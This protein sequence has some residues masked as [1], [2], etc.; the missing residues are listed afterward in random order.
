ME[1]QYSLEAGRYVFHLRGAR[2][3]DCDEV[4][5]LFDAENNVLLK[6]GEPERVHQH[7]KTMREELTAAGLTAEANAL[8]LVTGR[9]AVEELNKVVNICDYVGRFWR[10]LQATG[11]TS[12]PV[13]A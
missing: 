7:F 3:F 12:E 13:A 4:A 2:R 6:H 10:N 11:L 9:F 8:T 1:P 5:V